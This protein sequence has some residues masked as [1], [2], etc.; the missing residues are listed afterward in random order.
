MD[1]SLF[2]FHDKVSNNLTGGNGYIPWIINIIS[3]VWSSP[4]PP[5]HPQN[6][7]YMYMVYVYIYIY[8]YACIYVNK[9]V[10]PY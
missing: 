6:T 8:I 2:A 1:I 5:T 3:V 9:K 4:Q 7:T 10:Y